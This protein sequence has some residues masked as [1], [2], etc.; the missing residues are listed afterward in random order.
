MTEPPAWVDDFQ[1]RLHISAKQPAAQ[2]VRLG[3]RR[4]SR[5]ARGGRS[6]QQA[7][8]LVAGAGLGQ[9]VRF[10]GAQCCHG[11]PCVMGRG[12]RRGRCPGQ[13]GRG[14]GAGLWGAGTGAWP[15]QP[16]QRGRV[17]RRAGPGAAVRATAAPRCP[18]ACNIALA[19]HRASP[20]LVAGPPTTPRCS[21][22]SLRRL[23]PR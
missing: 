10:C 2:Q 23:C 22:R 11:G 5:S 7:Q 15:G 1:R 8:W 12:V 9:G 13:A 21:S 20:A 6:Q 4:R 19:S 18:P 17:L 16:P 3:S 14:V